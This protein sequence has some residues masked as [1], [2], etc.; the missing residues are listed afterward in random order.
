MKK[1]IYIKI[2]YLIIMAL[3]LQACVPMMVANKLL[4]A[5]V[6]S[7]E[8]MKRHPRVGILSLDLDKNASNVMVQ[9]KNQYELQTF[10]TLSHY[11]TV[12]KIDNFESK[13][14]IFQRE[15]DKLL[16][17]SQQKLTQDNLI[18]I[19]NA[20][21]VITEKL[22]DKQIYD[23]MKKQNLECIVDLSPDILISLSYKRVEFGGKTDIY[24]LNG[25]K[26]VKDSEKKI[27]A[28]ILWQ[29]EDIDSDPSWSVPIAQRTPEDD[30][31]LKAKIFP[32][33]D[34]QADLIAKV[35]FGNLKS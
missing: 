10:N 23:T 3:T 28:E 34:K 11:T 22:Y 4:N 5:P 14:T 19:F 24:T 29:R 17:I 1:N 13:G 7:D 21:R 16:L 15:V 8:D 33:I 27:R 18:I 35:L 2:I 30:E 12:Q 26:I 25:E 20:A 6:F 9:V 31:K 32:M